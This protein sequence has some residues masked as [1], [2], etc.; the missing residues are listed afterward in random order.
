MKKR[1]EDPAGC[2]AH[3]GNEPTRIL[4]HAIDPDEKGNSGPDEKINRQLIEEPR[5]GN[6][7]VF[8]LESVGAG[9][10]PVMFQVEIEAKHSAGEAK[11][12]QGQCDGGHGLEIFPRENIAVPRVL[13]QLELPRVAP[14]RH[15]AR[16][17]PGGEVTARQTRL[18]VERSWP[19]NRKPVS[20]RKAPAELEA[21]VETS[22]MG[23]RMAAPQR[24]AV[25]RPILRQR[26]VAQRVRR[27]RP[28]GR[29]QWDR[30]TSID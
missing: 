14:P 9:H 6:A 22:A 2:E 29:A 20:A 17:V 1:G 27:A 4:A 13:R 11:A 15:H 30:S 3:A 21:R 8:F 19:W 12:E 24:A 23:S 26:P 28:C 16:L 7:H 25:T 18:P 5:A 10:Q